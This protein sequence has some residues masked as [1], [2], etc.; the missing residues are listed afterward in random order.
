MATDFPLRASLNG[1]REKMLVD[2]REVTSQI[3]HR[4]A[5]GHER[6]ALIAKGYLQHYVPRTLEVIQGAEILDSE[7]N[8]SAECDLVVQSAATPP[9][10]IG[11]AFHLVP[12]EW[13]YGVIEVKSHLDS[14]QLA[15]AQAKIARAKALRKLTYVEQTGD[16]QWSMPAYGETFDHFPM[17]GMVFAYSASGLAGLCA[18]LWDL[19]QEVPMSQWIDAVI[20]IDQGLLLYSDASGGGWAVR[21]ERGAYMQAIQSDN[22][23]VAATL[24]LQNAFGSVFERPARLGPYMGSEPW[25]EIVGIAGP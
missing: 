22:A 10:M 14:T 12:V 20:V 6:E 21:P 7:G 3:E 15:D 18:K 25:G 17:Y 4:G 24:V 19:Q 8:R 2:F 23:L 1:L 11:E 13:A 5:K 16:V 9:L